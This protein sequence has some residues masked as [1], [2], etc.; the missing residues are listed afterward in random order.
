MVILKNLGKRKIEQPIECASPTCKIYANEEWKMTGVVEVSVHEDV[1]MLFKEKASTG[2]WRAGE[3]RKEKT[4][5]SKPLP[6][7][8]P[9]PWPQNL[10]VSLMKIFG[11]SSFLI[12]RKQ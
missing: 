5:P 11:V 3:S 2:T 1:N 8:S 6:F 12:M 7:S 9:S 4:E 10:L